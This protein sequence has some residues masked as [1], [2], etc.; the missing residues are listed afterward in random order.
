MLQQL[1][2]QQQNGEILVTHSSLIKNQATKQEQQQQQQQQL[3]QQVSSFNHHH[4]K[5]KCG[6]EIF[7]VHWDG[8]VITQADELYHTVWDTVSETTIVTAPLDGVL[9]DVHVLVHNHS[10]YTTLDPNVP[11]FTLWTDYDC[12]K[13][14]ISSMM[15]EEDYNQFVTSVLERGKFFDP[16]DMT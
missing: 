6:D 12:I 7:K 16:D 3:Q 8:H 11:L 4:Y 2:Q 13:R 9:T 5:V 15:Y 14:R 1:Q 10:D